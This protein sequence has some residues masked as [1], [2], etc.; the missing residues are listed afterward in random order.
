MKLTATSK[1]T[2][3]PNITSEMV[4]SALANMAN[5]LHHLDRALRIIGRRLDHL[6]LNILKG[7]QSVVFNRTCLD[8]DLPP[9]Y[10]IYIR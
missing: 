7:K 1:L 2:Q 4:E 3:H 9:K 10:T 6:H 5:F 8:E